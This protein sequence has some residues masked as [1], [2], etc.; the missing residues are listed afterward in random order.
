MCDDKYRVNGVIQ[1]TKTIF[2]DLYKQGKGKGK[3]NGETS[4]SDSQEEGQ[5]SSGGNDGQTLDDHLWDK[6]EEMSKDED[7]AKEIRETIDTALRQGK[8]LAQKMSG[9]VP[10]GVEKILEPKIDWKEMMRLFLISNNSDREVSSWRKPN[11]RW[12]H[13]DIY[14][15]SLVGES[16]GKLLIGIDTSGSIGQHEISALL[17]S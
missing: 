14:L 17:R 9:N 1:D 11:R 2:D 5:Q 13:Q 8:M 10:R 12:I 6:A 4:S 7:K 15:P 3:G 16:A